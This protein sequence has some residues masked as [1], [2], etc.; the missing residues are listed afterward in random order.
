L[1]GTDGYLSDV[2]SGEENIMAKT[3]APPTILAVAIGKPA[4]SR[5]IK[6]MS[7]LT[8]VRPYINGLI[9]YISQQTVPQSN[10][11]RKYTIGTDYII[12]Y[13]E[14]YEDD[15]SFSGTPNLIFCMST[16]VVRKAMAFTATIPIV[17]VASEQTAEQFDKTANICGVNAQRI[18]IARD[19]YDKFLATTIPALQTIYVLHRVGNTA[20]TK[21]LANIKKTALTA[22]LVELDVTTA[23]G[24]DMQTLIKGIPTGKGAGLLVLPV[25]LFFGSATDINGWASSISVPVFWPVRD[26]VGPAIGGYGVSQEPS[27]ELMGKQVQYILEHP[28]QIPQGQDRWVTAPVSYRKWAASKAAAKSLNLKL[29]KH[30]ALDLL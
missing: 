6:D 8:G 5:I 7:Q 1:A 16:P 29:A 12:D 27:G 20:S 2:G 4:N 18:Q 24:Q 17:G 23:P 14:C 28:N 21:S 19:Y 13:Q 25:D 11:A 15:E 26:W 10:P 9:N 30:S 22:P 3:I